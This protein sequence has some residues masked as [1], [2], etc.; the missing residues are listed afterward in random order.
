MSNNPMKNLFSNSLRSKNTWMTIVTLLVFFAV[1]SF[2]LFEGTKKTVALT[3]N[4]QQQEVTTHADTVG[5]LLEEQQIEVAEADHVYPSLNTSI[6]QDLAV[7]WEQAQTIT[8]LVDGE[9][10]TIDTTTDRVKD[11]L[12]EAGVE[13]T[14]YDQIAPAAD[15]EVGQENEISIAKAYQVKLIDGTQEKIV[16]STSTTVADFLKQNSIQL[17]T[18]DRVNVDMEKV[19]T[20]DTSI[21]IT[22]VEKVTDVVEEDIAFKTHTRKDDSLLKG[23]NKVV[24][25]GKPGKLAKTVEITKE[26]GKIID[27]QVVEEQVKQEPLSKVV[28]EGTKVVVAAATQT[29]AKSSS[30]PVSRSSAQEPAGREFYVTATAYTAYC[31]GCSGITAT[32]IDLRS[33]PNLKVIAVDPRVIPLGSKVWVEGYGYAIAG[34]TG[35]AIKGNKIDIFIPTKDQA[36]AF[37]RKQVR[38]KVIN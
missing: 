31:T 17:N 20:P 4:G 6:A 23:Q 38:V 1:V 15:A 10:Q 3:V 8:I 26:N 19:V 36:L 25:A 29:A 21:Q 33:N 13:V 32:G 27:R 30:Q 34:D 35:G 24:R 11:I 7:E 5:E 37:G 14:E 16:W 28:H 22:R 2:I 12:A 18:L 9:K